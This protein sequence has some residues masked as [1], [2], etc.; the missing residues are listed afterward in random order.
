MADVVFVSGS[1]T[2]V[3]VRR[4]EPI[5]V[6]RGAFAGRGLGER[7]VVG[8]EKEDVRLRAEE[9]CCWMRGAGRGDCIKAYEEAEARVR[10]ME[11][12]WP[13]C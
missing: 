4:N 11:K 3:S 13:P 9:C 5:C 10:Q 2:R 1:C 7:T 6:V 12:A 8:Y